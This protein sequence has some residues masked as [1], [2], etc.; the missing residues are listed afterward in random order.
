MHCKSKV[1]Q[2]FQTIV[3]IYI[4]VITI[5]ACSSSD[6]ASAV[7][8]KVVVTAP[9]FIFLFDSTIPGIRWGHDGKVGGCQASDTPS[10]VL[11]SST[12]HD[13]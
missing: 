9:W 5:S 11:L 10:A 7:G 4:E 8:C 13:D 1:R 6:Q 2:P 3:C 12:E